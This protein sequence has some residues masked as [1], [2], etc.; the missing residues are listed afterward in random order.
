MHANFVG[1]HGW[2]DAVRRNVPAN[3]PSTAIMMATPAEEQRGMASDCRRIPAR[4]SFKR[5]V[6]LRIPLGIEAQCH[7]KIGACRFR[8]RG[9]RDF[10][11]QEK[12][13]TRHII[14]EAASSSFERRLSLLEPV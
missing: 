1:T 10:S 14:I 8:Y 5:Y 7:G 9:E 3:C 12:T 2:P 11:R 13:R 4:A 6:H